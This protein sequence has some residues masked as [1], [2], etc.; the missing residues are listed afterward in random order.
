MSSNIKIRKTCEFCKQSFIARKVVTRYCSHQC[1]QRAYKKALRDEKVNKA[2][3][4][5]QAKPKSSL[6]IQADFKTIQTKEF[7]TLKDASLLLNIT[8]VTLRR[9]IKDGILSSYKPGKKHLIRRV[10]IDKL[11]M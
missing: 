1:N 5:E 2:K 9:W 4:I 10:D 7:L 6:I 8:Q 11:I 3:I